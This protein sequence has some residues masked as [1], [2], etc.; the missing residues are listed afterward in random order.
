MNRHQLLECTSLETE[1][2]NVLD[3]MC[4]ANKCAKKTR[5]FTVSTKQDLCVETGSTTY[6]GTFLNKTK[7]TPSENNCTP[8]GKSHP[9]L[10]TRVQHLKAASLFTDDFCRKS[11][12]FYAR[13]MDSIRIW[14]SNCN[15]NLNTSETK[16]LRQTQQIVETFPT[17]QN[18]YSNQI[19][20]I[21]QIENRSRKQNSEM[22]KG[23]R[24]SDK[25]TNG[26]KQKFFRPRSH[27][28]HANP[29]VLACEQYEHSHIFQYLCLRV[30]RR[31]APCVNGAQ[32]N[33]KGPRDKA[34]IHTLQKSNSGT[35]PAESARSKSKLTPS[36]V[37]LLYP[38]LPRLH[39]P[40]S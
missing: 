6:S 16:R 26:P 22:P 14:H 25:R 7:T 8:N 36:Q 35:K 18:A 2:K 3:P 30:A 5:N 34:E 23:I 29:F 40:W 21:Q 11:Y 13:Q 19:K 37:I 17:T 32:E 38:P 9:I 10:T 20:K 39:D 28:T 27:R 15:C 4:K 33:K 31:S 12:M 1:N 24:R